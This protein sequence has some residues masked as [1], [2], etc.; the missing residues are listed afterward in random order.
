MAGLAV[1]KAC[2]LWARSSDRPFRNGLAIKWPN[3][4][5]CGSN[6]LAGILCEANNNTILVGIGINCSQDSFTGT[7]RTDPTS[8]R[9]ETGLAPDR[10]FLLTLILDGLWTLITRRT[11]WREELEHLLAWKGKTVEFRSGI[12]EGP[13]ERGILAGIADDGALI[14]ENKGSRVCFHSGELSPVID[15][16]S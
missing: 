1:A 13:P 8:I 12:T 14:L 15:E 11:A 4:V 6:K 16:Y 5:L 2:L 3:D 9:M 10:N 7:Y